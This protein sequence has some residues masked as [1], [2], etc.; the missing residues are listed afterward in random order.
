MPLNPDES[1][2]RIRKSLESHYGVSISVIISDT[3]GRP[4]RLGQTNVAIGVSGVPIFADYR[5]RQDSFGNTM[6]VSQIAV[7]DELAVLPNWSWANL[8]AFQRW[9]FAATLT[10]LWMSPSLR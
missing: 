8:I 7:V 9:S 5:G 3:F 6:Q 4:W 10:K 1:A 2:R